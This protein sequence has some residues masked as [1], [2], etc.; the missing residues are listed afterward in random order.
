MCQCDEWEVVQEGFS[1]GKDGITSSR[2][3][4]RCQSCADET[5]EVESGEMEGVQFFAD[6]PEQNEP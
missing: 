6:E 3:V 5:R 1:I 2:E 4:Q